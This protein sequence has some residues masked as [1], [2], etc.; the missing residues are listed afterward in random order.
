M[1]SD[2]FYSI[3]SQTCYGNRNCSA[4]NFVTSLC[5]LDLQ[6]RSHGCDKA[7]TSAPIIS[8]SSQSILVWLPPPKKLTSGLHSKVYALI[9]FKFTMI[10]GTTKLCVLIPVW[11]APAFIQ[12]RSSL[13]KKKKKYYAHLLANFSVDLDEI[14]YPATA[15]TYCFVEVHAK[16]VQGRE[17]CLADLLNIPLRPPWVWTLMNWF[18]SNLVWW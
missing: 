10:I 16:Y 2:I 18:L 1:Q 11:M 17:L 6:S 3:L 9:A 13:R 14:W 7:K 4:L 5:D 12:S 15:T 8:Q